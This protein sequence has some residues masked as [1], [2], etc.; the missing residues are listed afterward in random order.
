VQGVCLRTALACGLA[1]QGQLPHDRAEGLQ[2]PP[3]SG[4]AFELVSCPHY[5]AEVL[6]YSGVLLL[7]RGR[8]VLAL[9]TIWV[10]SGGHHRH[11][12]GIGAQQPPCNPGWCAA[13][14]EQVPPASSM[15]PGVHAG[16]LGLGFWIL[17]CT[18]FGSWS[19]RWDPRF[20][21]LDPGVH[22]GTLGLGF[23]IL[24]CTLGP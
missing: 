13:R 10:V 18:G 21:V 3:P 1:A 22:V 7:T 15:D 14:G 6:I 20:R 8:P 12:G 11:T 9:V 19:A 17:E 24:E 16:T 4:G 23:W 2:P 5:L